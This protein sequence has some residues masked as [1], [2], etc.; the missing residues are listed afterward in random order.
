MPLG[1]PD[2]NA[3]RFVESWPRPW[4]WGVSVGRNGFGSLFAEQVTCI[5][6]WFQPPWGGLV[7]WVAAAKKKKGSITKNPKPRI[8]GKQKT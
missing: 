7:W 2:L 5:V 3:A 8:L 6:D 4:P 1:G